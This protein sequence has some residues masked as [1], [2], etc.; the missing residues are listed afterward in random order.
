[1]GTVFTVRIEQDLDP[2]V[3]DEVAGWWRQVERRFSTFLPDSEISAIG[4]GDLTV[5]DA[6][7]DVR[8]VLAVCE[9]IEEM[10]GGRFSIRPGRA[11]G[12]GIDPAGFVKG[13]SVDEAALMLRAAGARDFVIYAGGD[14]LCGGRPGD[15]EAWRVGIRL[16]W[17]PAAIGAVVSLRDGA[18]ASSGAYAR[19]DH[20]WGP[21]VGEDRLSGVS[22]V[23]PSLGMADAF[24][25][26]VYADQ[27]QSVD[28]LDAHRDYSLVLF[29]SG[30][31]VQWSASLE[32]RIEV[33]SAS[34]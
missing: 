5:E 8:H 6:H 10:S 1:M 33:G 25:T 7:R 23:G 30:R 26:A 29:T 16:P 4:R 11:G 28:W 15:G 24:A 18:I 13:W 27:A 3:L 34:A 31:E 2:A 22:V 17:Q 32:G 12:P 19:G 9:E 20:I 14:V 21:G